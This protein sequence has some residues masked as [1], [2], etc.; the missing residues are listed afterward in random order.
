MFLLLYLY[1]VI[2]FYSIIDAIL[3]FT[4]KE[5]TCRILPNG[6]SLFNYFISV[7][8]NTDKIDRFNQ[9]SKMINV[10]ANIFKVSNQCLHIP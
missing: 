8:F 2:V 7:V 3:L 4:F 9:S 1:S 5:Y 10:F 6:F